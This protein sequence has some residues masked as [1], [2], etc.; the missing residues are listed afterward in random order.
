MWWSPRCRSDTARYAEPPNGPLAGHFS[1][2]SPVVQFAPRR[3]TAAMQRSL[4]A[5][6]VALTSASAGI[7]HAGEFSITPV[8]LDLASSARSQLLSVTNLGSTPA[9]FMVRAAG[10]T[11]NEG[12]GVDLVP[13]DSLLVF[14]ASF[15]IPPKGTQNVRAGTDLAPADVERTWR[16]VLEELPDPNPTAQQ[17][18]TI[19]VLSQL[20]VP[21]FMAPRQVRRELKLGPPAVDGNQARILVANTGNV[22]ALVTAV[23]LTALREQQVLAE[24]RK[25]GWYLLPGSQRTYAITG[26]AA[27][28]TSGV[29]RFELR[30]F[31]RDGQQLAQQALDAREVCR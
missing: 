21:V 10:W 15:T 19:N 5:A 26:T 14:P 1:W 31:D 12:G 4:I 16:I 8:R 27:W 3:Y 11:V 29:N 13:D 28:C 2:F 18:T 24:G 6:L 9:R 25:E 30:A 22:H 7:T 17:G 23:S 20:S